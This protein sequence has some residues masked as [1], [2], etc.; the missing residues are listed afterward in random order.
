MSGSIRGTN[1]EKVARSIAE[2]E[3]YF[4]CDSIEST[5]LLSD[6]SEEWLKEIRADGSLVEHDK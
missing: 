5:W 1:N 2:C 3:D 4:V 6:G